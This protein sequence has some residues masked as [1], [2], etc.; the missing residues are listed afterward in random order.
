MKYDFISAVI[1]KA[2]YYSCDNT[3]EALTNACEYLD[4]VIK[5]LEDMYPYEVYLNGDTAEVNDAM[6]YVLSA[7]H[8]ALS[9]YVTEAIHHLTELSTAYK[10]ELEER[11]Y[12]V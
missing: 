1:K 5:N 8:N 9:G 3:V 10:D 7:M 6:T 2:R 12:F 4:E 11:G